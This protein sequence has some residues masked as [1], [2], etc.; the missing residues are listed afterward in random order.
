MSFWK[1]SFSGG[2]ITIDIKLLSYVLVPFSL[3]KFAYAGEQPISR[4]RGRAYTVNLHHSVPV[5]IDVR[6]YRWENNWEYII[7]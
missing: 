2:L 1:L 3:R 7:C 5:A 4:E 6:D